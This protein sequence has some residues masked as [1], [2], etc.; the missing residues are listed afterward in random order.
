[1]SAGNMNASFEAALEKLDVYEGGY[2]DDL[3]DAGRETYRGISRRY[4][5]NWEGWRVID[6]AKFDATN[7]PENLSSISWLEKL[8]CKFY[9]DNYWCK[10]LGTEISYSYS[11]VAE[12]L[13]DQSVN[14]GVNNAIVNL[15]ESLNVLNRN[16]SLF[17]DLVV[18]GVM[19]D[20][21]ICALHRLPIGDIGNLLKCM[22]IYQGLHYLKLIKKSSKYERFA[23]GWLKRVVIK[24]T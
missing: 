22:N 14:L 12:E 5:P 17:E 4:H 10:F 20:F 6:D 13:L 21:T 19:G 24:K 16:E 7:F 18:D 23:R 2:S 1:M 8:V 11:K 3:L 15:Q 9:Y